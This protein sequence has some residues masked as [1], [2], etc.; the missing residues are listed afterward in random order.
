MNDQVVIDFGLTGSAR[1]LYSEAIDLHALGR[2]KVRRATRIEFDEKSQ[3]WQVLSPD[4]SQV[5]HQDPRRGACLAW[6][7]ANLTA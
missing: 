4:G 5:L 2:L 6:E 3:Q 1:C 7:H